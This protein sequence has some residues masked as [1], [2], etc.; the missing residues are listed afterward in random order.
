MQAIEPDADPMADWL[1]SLATVQ[2][3]VPDDVLVLPA[4]NDAFNGLHARIEQLRADQEQA[5]ARLRELLREPRRVLDTFPALFKRPV[6]EA[7]PG[8]LGMATGEAIACLNDL[9]QRGEV[10][11]TIDQGV[12]W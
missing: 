9:M 5:L 2:A 6:T 3:R 10:R 4:H 11:R 1:A 8:L 12:A 7:D